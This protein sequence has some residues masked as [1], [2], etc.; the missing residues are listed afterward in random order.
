MLKE[1]G[2]CTVIAVCL[3]LLPSAAPAQEIV[4]ALAGT[5]RS[6]D[7]ANK[8][9]AVN[10]EDGSEG[11]FSDTTKSK[12]EIEFDKV[13]REESTPHSSFS[14]K[15]DEVVVYYFGDSFLQRTAVALQDLGAGPF[16]KETG[17]VVKY[18]RHEHLLTIKESSGTQQSFQIAANTPVETAVGVVE[19]AKY[20]PEK[21][22]QLRVIT[23]NGSTRALFIREN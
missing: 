20:D 16:D 19:G 8:T 22:E 2:K 13:L 5:V 9:I 23:T 4:H 11:V 6:V 7:S 3:C 17:T 21:G 15:G 1:N 10:T 14:K 12:S 18:N